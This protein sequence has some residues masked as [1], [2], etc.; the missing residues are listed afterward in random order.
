MILPINGLISAKPARTFGTRLKKSIVTFKAR[1][2]KPL[3]PM[4]RQQSTEEVTEYNFICTW[5]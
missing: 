3:Q 1:T 5:F 2:E 4:I